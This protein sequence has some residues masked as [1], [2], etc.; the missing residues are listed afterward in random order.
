MAYRE[1]TGEARWAKF[2]QQ[3][4]RIRQGQYRYPPDWRRVYN[5]CLKHHDFEAAE[6]IY[7]RNKKSDECEDAEHD[8]CFFKWCRCSCHSAVQFKTELA[9]L[10]S[11]REMQSEQEELEVA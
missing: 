4:V 1:P 6:L 7:D 10:L 2:D 11:C 5:Y 3:E 8:T 9:P